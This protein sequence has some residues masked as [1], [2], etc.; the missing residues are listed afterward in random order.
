[1]KNH[2]TWQ[3]TTD[4]GNGVIRVSNPPPSSSFKPTSGFHASS[5]H[6]TDTSE[7]PILTAPLMSTLVN[8]YFT[9]IGPLFPLLSKNEF[10]EGGN[11]PPLLLYAIAGVA[12]ARRGVKRE[13][14]NAIRTVLNGIIQNNDILCEPSIVNV[15]ALVR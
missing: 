1:M 14:F 13:V 5:N 11:P 4:D 8:S 7:H 6:P 10:V 2:Q 9:H 15:Q 3:L 12:S